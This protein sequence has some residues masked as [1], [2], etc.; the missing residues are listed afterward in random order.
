MSTKDSVVACVRLMSG[1]QATREWRTFET[2]TDGLLGLL[3]WLVSCRCEVVAMEATGA[4]RG[5]QKAI[6]AVAAS[7]LTAIYHVLKNGVVHADL[8]A[9]Y[10]DNRPRQAK[11]KRLVRQ[12]KNLGFEATLQ[13][14]AEAAR[15]ESGMPMKSN[16]PAVVSF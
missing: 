7:I 16:R 9:S 1:S 12:L 10:F 5:P 15:T 14:I 2:A 11:L 6:C 4:K 13:P 3:E 8:G